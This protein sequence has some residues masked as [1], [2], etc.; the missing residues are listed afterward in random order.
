M[1]GSRA[2]RSTNDRLRPKADVYRRQDAQPDWAARA[3]RQAYMKRIERIG[4]M[5]GSEA[6]G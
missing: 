1:L 3:E 4:E 5:N 6:Q 2:V